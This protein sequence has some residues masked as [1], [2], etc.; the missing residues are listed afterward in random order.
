M[1]IFVMNVISVERLVSLEVE[2]G[3]GDIVSDFNPFDSRVMP[4]LSGP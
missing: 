4:P 3:A 1:L 2:T